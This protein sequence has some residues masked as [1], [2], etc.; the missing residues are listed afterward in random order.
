MNP[1]LRIVLAI[2]V[3]IIVSFIVN[4]GLIILGS[5]LIPT[6]GRSRPDGYGNAEICSGHPRR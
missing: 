4:M 2:A 3:G 6:S 5:I 1:T